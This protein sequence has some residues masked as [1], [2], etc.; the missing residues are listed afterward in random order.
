MFT[1]PLLVIGSTKTEEMNQHC[2]DLSVKVPGLAHGFS[3]TVCSIN[4]ATKHV[5]N[6]KQLTL[7]IKSDFTIL[8]FKSTKY[9]T[10]CSNIRGG[11]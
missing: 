1:W 4:T 11:K 3:S 5:S 10:A 6:I 2:E 7:T 9:M 8:E